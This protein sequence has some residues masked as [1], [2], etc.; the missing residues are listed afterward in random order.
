MTGAT[1]TACMDPRMFD[2]AVQKMREFFR[3]R[4][5]VEV[6]TNHELSILAA[7]EDPRT[8][9]RFT[10]AGRVWPLPQ[11]GQM[12]LERVLLADPSLPGVFCVSTSFREEPDPIPGRHD[13]IFPMFEFETHGGVDTLIELEHTLLGHLG[14]DRGVFKQGTYASVQERFGTN[15]VSHQIEERIG[16]EISPVFFL[17]DFPPST[18]PF[19]NMAR[20]PDGCAKKVDG[21]MYGVETIGSAERSCDSGSMRNEFHAIS[22]GAYADTLFGQFGRDRVLGE[23]DTFLSSDFIPRCGGGIGMTRMIRAMRLA[24]LL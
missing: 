19:W 11:T 12:H 7:C 15:D 20:R 9:G 14:F 13:L 22:G 18:S 8:I 16:Q 3:G 21:I 23:L 4:G 1:P 24:K 17:T 5:F 10:F 2:G 6:H